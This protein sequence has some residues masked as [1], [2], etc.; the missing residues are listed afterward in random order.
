VLGVNEGVVKG[1]LKP[2]FIGRDEGDGFNLGLKMVEEFG[3][4]TGSPVGVVS[5]SAVFDGNLEQ[6]EGSLSEREMMAGLYH[7]AGCFVEQPAS[8]L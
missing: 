5:N 4:Q 8:G 3:C 2:A 7:R 1:Y 6:H